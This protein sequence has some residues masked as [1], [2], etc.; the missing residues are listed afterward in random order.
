MVKT[1]KIK[2]LLLSPPKTEAAPLPALRDNFFR[3]VA[4]TVHSYKIGDL[5]VASGVITR[6]QLKTALADQ[7][8]SGEQLGRVLIRQGAVSAVH[9]YQKL[10]QQWCIK[11][12]T[13]G[14]AL[15]VQTA[16]PAPARAD[17][18]NPAGTAA[19]F[20]LASA[21]VS[22]SSVRSYPE[23]FG[24][25]EVRSN[26]ITAFKKWTEVMDRFDGQ[27]RSYSSSAPRV[28]MWKAEIR[29]LRD[30]TAREKIE[31]I[32]AFLNQV[33][34]V[35]D[36]DNYGKTDY[37]ATPI[38]FLSRGGDCEDYAIAKY[39]SLRALG[40]S[41]DQLRIAIVQDKIKNIPH[42]ILV[43]YSDAGNFVLDNQDKRVETIAAV[44][45][46]QPIF[47]INSNSWWL[48]RA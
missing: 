4:R 36:I 42:A 16:V 30:R 10:A 26:D 27:M 17:D 22:S 8:E 11:V 33:P 35:E 38:E 23:L 45:R 18:S 29:R 15:L 46:Y 7:K 12:S 31:G 6:T 19:E 14:M 25:H 44:N 3:A 13:A 32:N 21:T 43:V 40:F 1:T 39:A 24:T 47:S 41:A 2:A 20:T 28:M 5:L 48:H 9:L 34:Y 37:W